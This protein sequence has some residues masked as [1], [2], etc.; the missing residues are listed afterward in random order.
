MSRF[1]KRRAAP[2]VG[3]SEA[4]FSPRFNV[5][6]VR[7]DADVATGLWTLLVTDAPVWNFHHPASADRE[8]PA[9]KIGEPHP[10]EAP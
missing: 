2:A 9:A 8:L 1:N 6:Q 4:R 5:N 10:A 7:G 3:N